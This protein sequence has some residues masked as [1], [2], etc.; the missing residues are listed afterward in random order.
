MNV[1]PI[2]SNSFATSIS[3]HTPP[4]EA[5]APA[6]KDLVQA[7]ADTVT[8][9][10]ALE[11]ELREKQADGRDHAGSEVARMF[12]GDDPG[13]RV[14]ND[15]EL[16]AQTESDDALSK[17]SSLGGIILGPLVGTAIGSPIGGAN[18]RRGVSEETARESHAGTIGAG[19]IS[20]RVHAEALDPYFGAV[21]LDPQQ[22]AQDDV[23]VAGPPAPEPER[24]NLMTAFQRV[25]DSIA[26]LFKR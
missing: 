18:D 14:L 25:L 13:A 16:K 11:Q 2:T 17:W 8:T 24:F 15:R 22:L 20:N 26:E 12:F 23:R 6:A 19:P 21:D 7:L 3:I 1:K 4:P 9:Q 10:K 5:R